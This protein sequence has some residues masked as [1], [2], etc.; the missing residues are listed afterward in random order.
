MIYKLHNDARTNQ[1]VSVIQV[2]D[3]GTTRSFLIDP[4]NTDYQ[5]FVQ[6]CEQGNTPLP[7]DDNNAV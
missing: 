1:L 7:A 4:A 6:W 5:E 2:N 3:D